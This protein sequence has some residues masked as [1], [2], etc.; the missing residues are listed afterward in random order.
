M[1]VG[2]KQRK[3]ELEPWELKL[4][5]RKKRYTDS[6][7]GKLVANMWEQGEADFDQ[8]VGT[9]LDYVGDSAGAQAKS[10]E[11]YGK[12][13]DRAWGF[14]QNLKNKGISHVLKSDC[15]K[16]NVSQT[17][18]KM[19]RHPDQHRSVSGAVVAAT[20][21]AAADANND[22]HIPIRFSDADMIAFYNE[23]GIVPDQEAMLIDMYNETCKI[24][25]ACYTDEQW[26][27][28]IMPIILSESYKKQLNNVY[29]ILHEEY[30]R[31][32][33]ISEELLSER[34]DKA[35]QLLGKIYQGFSRSLANHTEYLESPLNIFESDP[36]RELTEQ[37]KGSLSK[38]ELEKYQGRQ[39]SA[40]VDQREANRFKKTFLN[41]K[42]TE[43]K[44]ELILSFFRSLSG[45]AGKEA[46][47]N[48]GFYPAAIAVDHS[49]R[50]CT[51]FINSVAVLKKL[52]GLLSGSKDP[53]EKKTYAILREDLSMAFGISANEVK[54]LLKPE[55]TIADIRTKYGITDEAFYGYE[56]INLK[57]ELITERENDQF[58]KRFV[59]K[60]GRTVA[61]GVRNVSELVVEK[62][63]VVYKTVSEV[64][65]VFVHGV[66]IGEIEV[67]ITEDDITMDLFRD[68]DER[69]ADF[70]AE[71]EKKEAQE[72]QR[73]AKEDQEREEKQRELERRMQEVCER[74]QQYQRVEEEVLA[75]MQRDMERDEAFRVLEPWQKKL[76]GQQARYTDGWM[77][78]ILHALSDNFGEAINSGVD[79]LLHLVGESM[80][81]Q[82]EQYEVYGRKLDRPWSR[83][84]SLGLSLGEHILES[85]TVSGMLKT[86]IQ[87]GLLASGVEQYASGELVAI[88]CFAPT[89]I[90][91]ETRPP[92]HFDPALMA[93]FYNETGILPDEVSIVSDMMEETMK[94]A[95]SNYTDVQWRT[96][97]MPT[98]ITG[99][100]HRQLEQVFNMLKE[101][102]IGNPAMS[103]E[104]L[105]ERMKKAAH[106]LGEMYTD[107]TRSLANLTEYLE[108]PMNF[109]DTD[110]KLSLPESV[111]DVMTE[112]Q[113]QLAGALQTKSIT[114][115]KEIDRLIKEHAKVKRK[116]TAQSL[117]EQ[118]FMAI[119]GA[120]GQ[121]RN[122]AYYTPVP[123]DAENRN[124]FNEK[125]M[126]GA[127]AA[128]K[129]MSAILA[130]KEEKR[131]FFSKLFHR[132]ELVEERAILM[133]MKEA[134]QSHYGF[135]SE[136]V[137]EWL[138]PE[139]S[140]ASVR[141]TLGITDEVICGIDR[142]EIP[143]HET[144]ADKQ[145]TYLDT[146]T[147]VLKKGV[148][149][150]ATVAIGA[151][152]V[153]VKGAIAGGKCLLKTTAEWAYDR[154]WGGSRAEEEEDDEEEIVMLELKKEELEKAIETERETTEK[155]QAM[156]GI[157]LSDVEEIQEAQ[158]LEDEKV[159]KDAEASKTAEAAEIREQDV[160]SQLADV[161]EQ[162][163]IGWTAWG[164]K[165][166]SNI[167]SSS[168]YYLVGSPEEITE[169]QVREQ[170]A[171]KSQDAL[172]EL[173]NM[174]EADREPIYEKMAWLDCLIKLNKGMTDGRI[175]PKK[176]KETLDNDGLNTFVQK[177]VSSQR[178]KKACD[179][180]IR[181]KLAEIR[182]GQQKVSEEDLPAAPSAGNVM[183]NAL[184]QMA[185]TEKIKM[186]NTVIEE[187]LK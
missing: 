105:Q 36:P 135:T 183:E 99:S 165:I 40:L 164:L 161:V 149:V 66:Q 18:K 32:P 45:H 94:I 19:L 87:R 158:D 144:L 33:A 136:Q 123:Y 89:L 5:G 117:C 179:K 62:G 163:N 85:E 106:G 114:S 151:A 115:E 29:R 56:K 75:D 17:L 8:V 25:Q 153:L 41:A 84:Q 171:A 52:S 108:A 150:A 181:R 107:F 127:I 50:N 155:I 47:Q 174:D 20:C 113:K 55:V 54:E 120:I 4:I 122:Y 116:D 109:L 46:K 176:A 118:F 9:A 21:F 139:V 65:S 30:M 11:L 26:R 170:I 34:M 97:L 43:N 138:K 96:K 49:T 39:T 76:I 27:T 81:P 6:W 148:P 72:A 184:P 2:E 59:R 121:Q 102:Y 128:A 92:C 130:S 24:K 169:R 112:E 93:K 162:E 142:M 187:Q 16:Q 53:E 125:C 172:R 91:G 185:E 157:S 103:Q 57:Q 61:E 173:Q 12:K 137:E 80:N 159:L 74:I 68:P 48:A 14:G 86:Q 95:D 186:S 69:W 167:V 31:T 104:I 7:L 35:Q 156:R 98:I 58:L 178:F 1:G 60:M 145:K 15:V 132:K 124:V 126:I 23:L 154:F 160:I 166:L 90:H 140:L 70:K 51:S 101:E 64:G 133:A 73:R 143:P 146:A 180:L 10:Y 63:S 71:Q 3:K 134:L 175:S 38:E 177:S 28:T 152:K 67:D 131:G 82:L 111:A 141:E 42:R 83:I 129:K 100:Y 78:K 37:M 110:A 182:S 44:E 22:V 79:K 77:G 168:Y 13:V 119:S 88:T 147:D